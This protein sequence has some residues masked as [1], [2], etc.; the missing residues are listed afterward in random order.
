VE[1]LH[2]PGIFNSNEKRILP[3]SANAFI[4]GLGRYTSTYQ[5]LPVRAANVRI[6]RDPT[7]ASRCLDTVI[8]KAS[9]VKFVRRLSL[10]AG[11][12]RHAINDL[13]L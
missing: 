7:E 8:P 5:S 4:L 1:D 6:G 11:G 12:N 2:H 9:F 13:C 10:D 3:P